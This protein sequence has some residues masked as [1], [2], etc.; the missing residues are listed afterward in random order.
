VHNENDLTP[1]HFAS[2]YGR[3]EM[4]RL[5]LERGA[6]ADSED[7]LGRTPLHLVAKCSSDIGD[8]GVDVVH[9]LLEHGAN[10]NAQ[11]KVNTTPLH[12][13]SYCGK[14]EIARV[15]LDSG[16]NTNAKTALGLT[17]LDVSRGGADLNAKDSIR[18][19]PSDFILACRRLEIASLLQHH[20]DESDPKINQGPT[21]HQLESE[22]VNPH[23]KPAPST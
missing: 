12:L 23:D 17:P 9:L 19:T 8:N 6:T 18:A 20:G 5:L 2:F 13:A 11:D 1:L 3:V 4:V 21:P 10:I 7:S 15:L 14:V 22:S 16:A